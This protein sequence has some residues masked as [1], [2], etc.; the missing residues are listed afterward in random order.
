MQR[1]WSSEELAERW[2][3]GSE[4]LVLLPGKSDAGKLGFA[5]QL[6]FY[7]QYARFPEDESDLAPAV[8]AHLADKIGVSAVLLDGYE[9]AGRTGRRHRQLIL[10]FLAVVPFEG[11]TESTF[12]AWL[13]EKALPSEPNSTALEDQIGAWFA[14]SRVTRPGSYRLDRL[15]TAARLAYD[16]RTFR[17][18][19]AHLDAETRC[20]LDGLL[21]D[22]GS[23][24]AFSRLQ[25]DPGRVGLETLLAEIGKLD[26]VR[27]LRL[28]PDILKRHHPELIKAEID[29]R[30]H[31]VMPGFI[32]AV[33]QM[34]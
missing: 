3:L 9:W 18:V 20:R 15:V 12:R 11:A 16:E 4:E 27:S 22:D 30:G 2:S 24:A 5:V 32:A 31:I 28:P 6:A 34:R 29:A 17:T 21:A 33:S 14:R 23:G 7:K 10:D 19:A 13:A 26:I 8:I 1:M 25:A